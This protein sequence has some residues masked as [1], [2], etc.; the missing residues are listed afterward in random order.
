L[1]IDAGLVAQT[2]EYDCDAA[3]TPM[4]GLDVRV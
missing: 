1:V 2:S 3:L 4:A